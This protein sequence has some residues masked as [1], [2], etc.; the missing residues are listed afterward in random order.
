MECSDFGGVVV[1]PVPRPGKPRRAGVTMVIDKGLGRAETE[2]FLTCA[3][4]YVDI[5]KLGFG[6]ALL[7]SP[8]WL[9]SKIECAKRHNVLVYP[10]GTLLELAVYQGK[11]EAFVERVAELGFTAVEISEGTIEL[12]TATRKRLIMQ[13][14]SC[15]LAVLSEVGKKDTRRVFDVVRAAEAILADLD[16]GASWVIVE[17]RDSGRGVGVY[18]EHGHIRADVVDALMERVG[19]VDR[20]MWEAPRTHQQ[21]EWLQRFGPSVNL[22]NVQPPDVISL[23]ATRRGLRGDTLKSYVAAQEPLAFPRN[24]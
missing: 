1:A 21:N 12:D 23:E 22:G 10:G 20:L 6:T 2:D 4:P 24:L 15:G 11:G 16:T 8:E 7:Y 9:R 19:H 5:L 17:G 14:V 18:D 3:G 13:G